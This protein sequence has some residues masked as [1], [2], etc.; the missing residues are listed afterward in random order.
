MSEWNFYLTENRKKKKTQRNLHVISDTSLKATLAL[1][2]MFTFYQGFTEI[3]K[4][5]FG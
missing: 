4:H 2:G 5:N 1:I 3:I